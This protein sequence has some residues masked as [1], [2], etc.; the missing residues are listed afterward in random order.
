MDITVIIPAR[1]EEFLGRTI[2]DV[3]ENSEADTEVIAVLDGYLPN[4]PLKPDPR[5]TVIYNPSAVGQR[6]GANQAAKLARGKYIMK[7]DAHCAFDKGFDVKL[8]EKMQDNYTMVPVM[9]NLHAFDWVC[10]CGTRIYQGPTPVKCPACGGAMV[11]DMIWKPRNRTRTD[12]MRFDTNLKFQYWRQFEARPEASGESCDLMSFLGACWVISRHRHAKLG[13]LDER[14]GSWGQVG[15][16]MACKAWLSGGRLVVNKR[17]WFAHMFRTQGLDFGFPYSISE[18]EVD[19]ARKRS[20]DLWI[21]GK[22]DKAIRPL[23]WL[24]DKFAPVPDWH[25]MQEARIT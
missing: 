20:K 17:T 22:W 7:V 4:P 8:M 6:A 13:G 14:H 23:D 12:F 5:V 9:R 15:S 3:L 21:N 19:K 16:E 2:Q 10:G 24:V 1:N 11:R 18:K 25:D